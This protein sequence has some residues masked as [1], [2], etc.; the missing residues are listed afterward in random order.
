MSSNRVSIFKFLFILCNFGAEF[1]LSLFPVLASMNSIVHT[2][3]N[4]VL[5]LS[6]VVF[7]LCFK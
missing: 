1:T 3:E 2:F 6:I 5:R 7:L 4:R